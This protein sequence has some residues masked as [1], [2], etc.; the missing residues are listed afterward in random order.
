ML[1][2]KL[3]A[4]LLIALA[5]HPYV[6]RIAVRLMVE[7]RVPYPKALQIVAIEYVA[8]GLVLAVL[9]FSKLTGQTVAVTAAAIILVAVGA[10]LIGKWL[11]FHNGDRLGV[12]NGVLIQFM[13]VPLAVPFLILAS[14]L[15]DATK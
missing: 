6:L 7:V 5:I 13:Q 12:G 8:A 2:W 4:A 3:I 11:S 14:F 9:T 1:D 10:A 15:F